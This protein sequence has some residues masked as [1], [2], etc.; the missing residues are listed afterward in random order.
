[1]NRDDLD[2]EMSAYPTANP[3]WVGSV[4]NKLTGK[5][6]FETSFRLPNNRPFNGDVH[7]T[8]TR[9]DVWEHATV[10]NHDATFKE[11]V[12]VL[13]A[14][15]EMQY[16]GVYELLLQ[17]RQFYPNLQCRDAATSLNQRNSSYV[18]LTMVMDE[19]PSKTAWSM[20]KSV[21]YDDGNGFAFHAPSL[22]MVWNM[23]V[24]YPIMIEAL[25]RNI[26]E[27]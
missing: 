12:A 26:V 18:A 25:K 23:K 20:N 11:R 22:S 4:T 2:F 14:I 27:A 24:G 19:V 13:K 21:G 10:T 8:L 15:K 6:I 9:D 7:G 5:K 1:M 17:C 3:T 16:N